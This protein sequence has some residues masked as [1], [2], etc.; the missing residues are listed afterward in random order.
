MFLGASLFT[1]EC[2]RRLAKRL[3]QEQGS[4]V[5]LVDDTIVSRLTMMIRR[6]DRG[7]RTKSKISEGMHTYH[8]QNI[9][10][11]YRAMKEKTVLILNVVMGAA[12]KNGT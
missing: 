1:L 9:N 8:F 2:V 7:I 12:L 6:E 10:T 5:V 11:G 3:Q 4:K